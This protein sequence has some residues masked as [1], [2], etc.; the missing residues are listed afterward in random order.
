MPCKIFL[1]ITLALVSFGLLQ[2]NK[3]CQYT[4]FRTI[5]FQYKIQEISLCQAKLH[6]LST[7]LYLII[8]DNHL[9]RSK[10]LVTSKHDYNRSQWEGFTICF[11]I[12]VFRVLFVRIVIDH[13]LQMQLVEIRL[14]NEEVFL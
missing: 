7:R 12:S 2:V 10:Y 11:M 8:V 9:E 3:F 6:V 4:M 13:I 5:M 14:I 1:P